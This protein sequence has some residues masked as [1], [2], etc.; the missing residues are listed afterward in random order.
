[1]QNPKGDQRSLSQDSTDSDS[2]SL[3][4]IRVTQISVVPPP[5]SPDISSG[6]EE[7][8]PPPPIA[9]RSGSRQSKKQGVQFK[10]PTYSWKQL[11]AKRAT[12]VKKW[13]K[14]GKVIGCI[15]LYIVIFF[16][17][18]TWVSYCIVVPPAH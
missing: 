14:F 16:V 7:L 12:H 9:S 8:E 17:I 3:R 10:R 2:D 6:N 5:P 4:T 18:S 13:E 1:M 15:I 11:K